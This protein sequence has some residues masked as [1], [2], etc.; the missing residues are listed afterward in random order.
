MEALRK[1]GGTAGVLMALSGSGIVYFL[2]DHRVWGWILSGAGFALLLG[3]TVLNRE[4][5]RN[6][7]RGRPFRYGA[8]AV[9]YS[10]V[11]LGILGGVDFLAARHTRRFDL[12][13]QG[14]HTLSPQTIQILKGI[15]REGQ[16]VTV[17]AFYTTTA[18]GRQ[19]AIDLLEEYKY[20]T[21][22]L[23][24]RV[25]D[26]VRSPGEVRAY[27]VEQDGIVIVAAK[28]GEARVTPSFS[29]TGLTEEDLTNALIKATSTSKSVICLTTGHG[30]K[31][32]ADSGAGGF[33]HAVEALKK[34]NFEVREVRLL[35]GNGVAADCASVVVAGPTH[36]M[37]PPEIEALQTYLKG[38]GRALILV[39]PGTSTGLDPL[40]G[41]YGLKLGN[42]FI[43]DVNPM[44]RLMGGSPATPVVYEYGT[45]A[46][47]KDFEGL[48]TIFPTVESVETAPASEPDVTTETIAH[49]GAQSWG[50]RGAMADRVSFDP[51]QDKQGPLNVAAV[52][53]RK[54]KE[55][56]A[57][58]DPNAPPPRQKETR[59]VLFGDSD[60][61]SNQAFAL[62][63]N[64]DLFMNT[65]AWLNERSDL[66]SIRPRTQMPQPVVL[67]GLQA[68]VLKW[69]SLALSPLAALVVGAGVWLR[70]RR[71]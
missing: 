46:I 48:V 61:A 27:G 26:P 54:I 71:L 50:E 2:P 60:Y 43:V 18:A 14:V 35:E 59:L 24:V 42:D 33:Q 16:D 6:M 34:E 36:A 22:H 31:Q 20:L 29:S 37:L 21:S 39:E 32:I 68:R 47:T 10:L 70:R 15:D 62:G 55:A 3:A 52:A 12:T 1:F 58:A 67:T 65:M 64:K 44:A 8:N 45:H 25:L 5:L 51:G 13:S 23:T 19:A 9:F 57:P 69:Y 49:T 53:V 30:E 4:D 40:L 66:I 17:T 41:A 38:G 63:G 7:L 11:V 56:E 28:T